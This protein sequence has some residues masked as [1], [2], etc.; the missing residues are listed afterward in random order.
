MNLGER[1]KKCDMSKV[2]FITGTT[3]VT[4]SEIA[5]AAHAVSHR[6]VARAACSF[7]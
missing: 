7:F 4:G 5:E 6:V 3:R 2:W 1:N